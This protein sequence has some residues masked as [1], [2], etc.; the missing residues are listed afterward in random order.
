L[1]K[2]KKLIILM[3][4]VSCLFSLCSCGSKKEEDEFPDVD[5]N[6]SELVYAVQ[7][8][9]K[10]VS[11]W[12]KEELE[13]QIKYFD[14]ETDENAAAKDNLEKFLAIKDEVGKFED[15]FYDE[16]GYVIY[17][18]EHDSESITIIMDLKYEKRDV[19]VSYK[20]VTAKGAVLQLGGVEY[21]VKYTLK[22]KLTK[23][24][25]NTV[26]GLGTVF[27]VLILLTFCIS[28]FKY[29]NKAE[30]YFRRRA[31]EKKNGGAKTSKK[32]SKKDKKD[33]DH[34]KNEEIV[35]KRIMDRSASNDD[36]E[37]EEVGDDEELAAVIAA[38]I[39]AYNGVSSEGLVVRRIRRVQGTSNWR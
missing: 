5:Y 13:Y 14:D 8:N 18:V 38:A 23:A 19:T 16:D 22:E 35:N 4:V 11:G 20:Y 29:I 30:M 34:K 3:C 10:T 28:M 24:A 33:K 36:E 6:I 37:Y 9:V 39:T 17:D 27:I 1:K 31:E 2:L 32:E 15:Y 21:E 7:S 12:T 25:L 26:L